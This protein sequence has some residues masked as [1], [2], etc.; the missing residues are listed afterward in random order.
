[1]SSHI[2]KCSSAKMLMNALL[3]LMVV[4]F[5]GCSNQKNGKADAKHKEP[6]Y[7]VVADPAHTSQNALDWDGM[8]VG[9]VPCADCAG[10]RMWV[11]IDT[12][13][14]FV[15]ASQYLGK[16]DEV[17]RDSGA[18]HWDETGRMILLGDSSLPSYRVFRVVENKIIMLD[19]SESVTTGP[20]ASNYQLYKTQ[21]P[22]ILQEWQGVQ[23]GQSGLLL[24]KVTLTYDPAENSIS[25]S[26]GCNRF[27]GQLVF[28][29]EGFVSVLP[30]ATTKMACMGEESEQESLFLA[31]LN[32]VSNYTFLFGDLTLRDSTFTPLLTFKQSE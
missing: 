17:F 29:Q 9:V 18:F 24:N 20:L 15:V 22:T 4:S 10:I 26:T 8:Y 2:F 12:S 19:A 11:Q 31:S 23:H 13:L 32:Q 27:N 1:M 14:Q 6:E 28:S 30:I 25:G 7:P 16:S 3:F 21:V 5:F